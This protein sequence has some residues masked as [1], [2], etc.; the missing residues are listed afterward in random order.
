[1]ASRYKGEHEDD[2]DDDEEEQNDEAEGVI[3]LVL[4]IVIMITL[5]VIIFVIIIIF[6][7]TIDS[8]SAMPMLCI[9]HWLPVARRVDFKLLVFTYKAVHGDAPKYLSDLLCPYTPALACI[10]Y[11]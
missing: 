8:D 1:M 2:D 10:M 7:I 4:I 6:I 5:I 3:V 9:L 11:L